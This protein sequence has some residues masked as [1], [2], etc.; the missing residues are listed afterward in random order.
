MNE[1]R[2]IA[3]C[4]RCGCKEFN[5]KTFELVRIVDIEDCL[6]DEL[7]SGMNDTYEYVCNKCGKNHTEDE[8]NFEEY[9]GD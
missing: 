7:L 5:R 1:I 3:K 8:F 9:R 6:T 4:N 2:R